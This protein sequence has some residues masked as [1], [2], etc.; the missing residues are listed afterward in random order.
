MKRFMAI[1]LAGML[2][3]SAAVPS[4]AAVA[5]NAGKWAKPSI[6]FAYQQGLLTEADLQKAKS[7]MTRKDFCKMV[8]RFLNVITGKEWKAAGKTPFTDCDDADVTA[9]Y[10]LSII[11]GTDPGIFEP[12]STLTREQMA[13]MVARV[14]KT[15]GVDLTEK[16][17][18]N[19]FN[20][21]AELFASSNK[22]IDQLY[23]IGILAGYQDGGYHPF[24]EMTVQE[25]VVSFVKAYRYIEEQTGGKVGMEDY[26]GFYKTNPRL[27]VGMTLAL[28]SLA[29]IPPFAG[30]FSKFFVFAAAFSGGFHLLVFI[31]LVN[32][33][34]SLYYYLLIV[35]AMYIMPGDAPIAAFRSDRYTRVSLAL[36][37]AGVLLLGIVSAVYDGIN[38]FAFG[39]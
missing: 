1:L 35:K 29:G 33:V 15:C 38:A 26:N 14:M 18:K 24:R 12:N 21:T 8:M 19:P 10:E 27:A 39:L 7:P 2:S 22:Y 23:G 6:E 13:I 36:C 9:A 5:T 3:L 28:F 34:V 25:A 4:F 32:T 17:K 16:A 37:M 30:F 20:D 31:A 11:G